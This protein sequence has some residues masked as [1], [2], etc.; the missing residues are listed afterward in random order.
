MFPERS[1]GVSPNIVL[2][3][4]GQRSAYTAA[5]RR[6]TIDPIIRHWRGQGP[7]GLYQVP[8]GK[9][10]LRSKDGLLCMYVLP[11]Y[12][13]LFATYQ[14]LA[15]KSMLN[16]IHAALRNAMVRGWMQPVCSALQ[17]YHS[18]CTLSR[19]MQQ[20]HSSCHSRKQVER[21]GPRSVDPVSPPTWSQAS[22]TCGGSVG[23]PAPAGR[24]SQQFGVLLAA[25]IVLIKLV[26][27]TLANAILQLYDC[28]C[29][30][31]LRLTAID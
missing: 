23:R 6:R 12:I 9:Q 31:P 1:P 13:A 19:R 17:Y 4:Q 20:Q 10:R 11:K 14:K 16:G 26:H 21:R 22:S 5:K 7:V 25:N 24:V 3:I 28:A 30:R 18:M 2:H 29:L 8:L 27:L 15:S